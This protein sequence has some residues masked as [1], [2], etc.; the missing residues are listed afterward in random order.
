MTYRFE[1]CPLISLCDP[2]CRLSKR[3]RNEAFDYCYS[4]PSEGPEHLAASAQLCEKLISST[5]VICSRNY[6]KK[7]ATRHM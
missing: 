7:M 5:C 3:L 1:Q 2:F 6:Q 4:Y